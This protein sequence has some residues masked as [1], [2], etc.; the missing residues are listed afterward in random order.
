M[1]KT[2]ILNSFFAGIFT[3]ENINTIP[4]PEIC[5]VQ[6]ELTYL[7]ITQKIVKQ[8]L[9]KLKDNRASGPDLIHHKILIDSQT[10][11]V[12]PLVDIYYQSLQAGRLPLVWKQANVC[13]ISMKGDRADPANYRPVSL[14]I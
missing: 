12:L 4:N 2:N 5:S 8:L 1:N 13:P 11:L 10:E 14:S 3:D 6:S 7:S 9:V